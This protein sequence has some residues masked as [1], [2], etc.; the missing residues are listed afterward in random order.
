MLLFSFLVFIA[1]LSLVKNLSQASQIVLTTL[2][3][4]GFF[5]GFI[6]ANK[7]KAICLI[8]TISESISFPALLFSICSLMA[9]IFFSDAW[10]LTIT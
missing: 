8:L 5:N 6:L 1:W 2:D 4:S 7:V 9:A 3:C 10:L